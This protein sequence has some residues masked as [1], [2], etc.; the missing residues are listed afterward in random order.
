MNVS[1]THYKSQQKLAL[2]SIEI[3]LENNLHVSLDKMENKITNRISSLQDTR[4]DIQALLRMEGK[5]MQEQHK[6]I[7]HEYFLDSILS[8]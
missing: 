7:P 6:R 5:Q 4:K 3:F 8:Q 2:K 1:D